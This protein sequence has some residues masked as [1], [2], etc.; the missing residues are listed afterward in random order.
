MKSWIIRVPTVG[1]KLYDSHE[2]V[3]SIQSQLQTNSAR[4]FKVSQ[5][6][7]NITGIVQIC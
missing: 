1:F 2:S 6:F 3:I 7:N 5:I 4:N